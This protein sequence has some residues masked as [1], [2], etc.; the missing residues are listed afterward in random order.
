MTVPS[1]QSEGDLEVVVLYE[2]HELLASLIGP[3]LYSVG[4]PPTRGTAQPHDSAAFDLFL[5]RVGEMLAEGARSA[6]INGGYQ[7]WSLLG[8]LGW[9]SRRYP[10]E[11]ADSGLAS[12]LGTLT[13]WLTQEVPVSFWCPDVDTQ[14]TVSLSRQQLISMVANGTKH[15]LLRLSELLRKLERSCVSAGYTFTAQ[16]LVPVLHCLL[17]EGRSRLRYHFSYLT[18]ML[19]VLFLALNQLIVARFQQNPTNDIR[20]MNHPNGVTSDV[21]RDLYG[22]VLV[23]KRYA[24]S[25]ITDFTPETDPFLRLRY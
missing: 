8:G 7:N 14:I 18:E 10:D 12:A 16:Q 4:E 11:A 19:A 23:F 17:N 6:A 22:S 1:I 5:I 3:D 20:Q 24:T 9:L 15:S 21:F 13:S 2:S 25:R